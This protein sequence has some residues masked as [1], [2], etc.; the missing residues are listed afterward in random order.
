[1]FESVKKYAYFFHFCL[2][3][4]LIRSLPVTIA[5]QPACNNT[6]LT[7]ML[8]FLIPYYCHIEQS[9]SFSWDMSEQFGT[10][11]K[12]INYKWFCNFV[13]VTHQPNYLKKALFPFKFSLSG[14][15]LVN[16]IYDY[17]YY[18]FGRDKQGYTFQKFPKV[19]DIIYFCHSWVVIFSLM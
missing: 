3:T 8:A 12:G 13:F 16:C 2:Y 6:S 7:S 1:M 10:L 18:L 19:H 11:T 9:N 4:I 14:A 17:R 5:L 15:I